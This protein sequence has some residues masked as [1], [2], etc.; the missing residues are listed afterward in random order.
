MAAT[1]SVAVILLNR[2]R[3][4]VSIAATAREF[5]ARTAGS[6]TVRDLWKHTQFRSDGRIEAGVPTH[7]VAMFRVW[8]AS[9]CKQGE[10]PSLGALGFPPC[11]IKSCPRSGHRRTS[12]P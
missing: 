6:Y 1:G 3:G 5:G 12:R 4:P 8:P 11:P 10:E 7:A 2:G 9:P